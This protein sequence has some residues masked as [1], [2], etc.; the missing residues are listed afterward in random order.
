M[1]GKKLL[2]GQQPLRYYG[3]MSIGQ[4]L[5]SARRRLGLSQQQVGDHLGR[6]K[7]AVCC[8]ETD[9]RTPSIPDRIDLAKLLDIPF[10][11]LLPEIKLADQ[12]AAIADPTLQ[13]LTS[14]WPQLEPR[15]R[16]VV[17]MLAVTLTEP[18]PAPAE[19][20]GRRLPHSV[21]RAVAS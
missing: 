13:Q 11:D 2:L 21:L 17:L 15:L 7:T 20:R 18:Q 19:R 16:Q 12:P 1:D 6:T 5:F 10:H 3:S 4:R 8:W 9:T 14:L